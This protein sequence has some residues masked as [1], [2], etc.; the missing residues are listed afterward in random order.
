MYFQNIFKSGLYSRTAYNGACLVIGVNFNNNRNFLH[1]FYDIKNLKKFPTVF[2]C[3]GTVGFFSVCCS[4]LFSLAWSET[5]FCKA[6]LVTN[7]L[8]QFSVTRFDY[9]Y[10]GAYKS[11][12]LLKL[13]GL[14]LVKILFVKKNPLQD[15]LSSL[16]AVIS[17]NERH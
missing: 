15:L 6:C 13:Q 11:H 1:H 17:T 5:C 9:I 10:K 14:S 16:N 8:G 12:D 3:T 4:F 2:L 7:S